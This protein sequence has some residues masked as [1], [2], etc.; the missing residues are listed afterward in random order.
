MEDAPARGASEA[1]DLYL[2]DYYRHLDGLEVPTQVDAEILFGGIEDFLVNDF[3]I[4]EA[5]RL[6]AEAQ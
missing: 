6:V 5:F 1:E 4:L 2:L 3:V